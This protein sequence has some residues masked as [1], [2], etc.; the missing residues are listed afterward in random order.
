M[1]DMECNAVIE[2]VLHTLSVIIVQLHS[3]PQEYVFALVKI[4]VKSDIG[5]RCDIY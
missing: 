1:A 5:K 2:M 4:I 3:I